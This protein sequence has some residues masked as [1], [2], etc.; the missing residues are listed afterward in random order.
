ML[1]RLL[2]GGL[3]EGRQA[4]GDSMGDGRKRMMMREVEGKKTGN[5]KGIRDENK[6]P[7]PKTLG[8]IGVAGE[9]SM[10]EEDQ[11]LP[12]GSHCATQEAIVVVIVLILQQVHSHGPSILIYLQ[13]SVVLVWWCDVDVVV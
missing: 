12:E 5:M 8:G 4:G 13:C 9:G 10:A 1:L 11:G 7:R 3:V 6:K 2:Q